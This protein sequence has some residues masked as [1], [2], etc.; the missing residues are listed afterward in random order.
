LLFV[1]ISGKC[2]NPRRP[3]NGGFSG[4]NF[5]EGKE[6]DF[7]CNQG[8]DIIRPQTIRCLSTGE[9]GWSEFKLRPECKR[10]E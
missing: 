8:Y 2:G 6:L 7:F 5:F 9:W 1:G 10:K 4:S 3:D